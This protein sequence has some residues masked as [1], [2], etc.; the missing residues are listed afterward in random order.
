M[1]TS[2]EHFT[3]IFYAQFGGKQIELW[4]IGKN[5]NAEY[6]IHGYTTL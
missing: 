6:V 3:T 5:E 4:G 1:Q 2:Q